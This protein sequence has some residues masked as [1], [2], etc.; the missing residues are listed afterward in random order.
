MTPR[1]VK[2][3]TPNLIGVFKRFKANLRT[4]S[5]S[6]IIQSHHL[7]IE[8][9]LTKAPIT[10]M[11]KAKSSKEEKLKSFMLSGVKKPNAKSPKS[12]I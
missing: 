4:Y 1:G 12:R 11:P 8:I 2:V 9:N 6:G 7:K 3:Y 10:A 5:S